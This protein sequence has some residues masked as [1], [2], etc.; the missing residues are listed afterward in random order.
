M[1]F[2]PEPDMPPTGATVIVEGITDHPVTKAQF[3]GRQWVIREGY[4]AD[5]VALPFSEPGLFM[6]KYW[7]NHTDRIVEDL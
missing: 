3:D 6:T 5:S 2:D 4:R 1:N 7:W